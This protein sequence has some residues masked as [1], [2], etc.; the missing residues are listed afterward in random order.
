LPNF[1][2][3][4]EISKTFKLLDIQLYTYKILEALD[5]AHAHGIIHRDFKPNNLV[6][7]DVKKELRVIDWGLAEYYLQN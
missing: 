7:D 6:I 2:E 3:T 4:K 1:I 5:Y